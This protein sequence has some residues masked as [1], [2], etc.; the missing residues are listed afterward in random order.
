MGF[1]PVF[2]QPPFFA[3]GF[4]SLFLYCSEPQK[5]G[6]TSRC[7]EVW[8]EGLCFGCLCLLL[9]ARG[10]QVPAGFSLCL[11]IY[12]TGLNPSTQPTEVQRSVLRLLRISRERE[13]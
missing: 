5:E 1:L 12:D 4:P 10:T 3:R 6:L 11:K 8:P 2:G 9:S 7:K 13:E